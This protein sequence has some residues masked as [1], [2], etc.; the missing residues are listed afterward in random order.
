MDKE[1][2]NINHAITINERKSIAI[3]GVKKITSF[4]ANEFLLDTNMGFITLKGSD[5]EIVKNMSTNVSSETLEQIK[6]LNPG[7]A[8]AFG[9][10]F[11]VPVL[12]N[13]K[14]PNPMPISTSVD[15]KNIWYEKS[16]YNNLASIEEIL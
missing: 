14:L 15:I 10:S 9:T 3:T 5:L 16:D 12:I 8:F 1:I 13:F 7:C 4:N 2:S 6:S 11:K